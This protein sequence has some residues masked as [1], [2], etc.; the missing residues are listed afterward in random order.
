L[1]DGVLH[2]SAGGVPTPAKVPGLTNVRTVDAG[3]AHVCALTTPGAIVCWGAN[4]QG[5]VGAGTV[6]PTPEDKYIPSPRAT[7]ITSGAALISLGGYHSCAVLNNTRT[8]CWGTNTQG[9]LGDGTFVN[10]SKPGDVLGLPLTVLS[11]DAGRYEHTCA[12]LSDRSFW[13]WGML[14]G[15]FGADPAPPG[16]NTATPIRANLFPAGSVSDFSS[17]A[18][19]T[20]VVVSNGSVSCWGTNTS[21]QLGSGTFD[22]S[23]TPVQVIGW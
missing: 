19:H 3:D 11:I 22:H 13:C 15:T 6:P 1:G 18:Y 4:P 10:R 17:G 20:C 9:E 2:P 5:Q 16:T 8:Q 23:L 14:V 21:G 7:D 12:L